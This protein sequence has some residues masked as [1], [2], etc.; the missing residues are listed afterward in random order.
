MDI[1]SEEVTQFRPAVPDAA[2]ELAP[3]A[4]PLPSEISPLSVS[5]AIAVSEP[6]PFGEMSVL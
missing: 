1:K 6:R 2:A 3:S 4:E 5:A